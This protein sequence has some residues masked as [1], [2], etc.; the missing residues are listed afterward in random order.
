MEKLK[1]L[2]LIIFI[3][4]IT[5]SFNLGCAYQQDSSLLKDRPS[6]DT[7]NT[8]TE[9]SI[10]YESLAEKKVPP[11]V[12]ISQESGEIMYSTGPEELLFIEGYAMPGNRIDI[13]VNGVLKA[14]SLGVDQKGYFR[15]S[16]GVG[17]VEGNNS[18]KVVAK[19]SRGSKSVPTVF[20]VV[21]KTA[22]SI[23]Y[24]V[25]TDS[26]TLKEISEIYYTKVDNPTVYISGTYLPSS[27]I[28][29]EVNGKVV[30][31]ITSDSDGAFSFDEVELEKGENEIAVWAAAQ[32]GQASRPKFKNV[33]V[34]KDTSSPSPVNL[35]GYHDNSGNHLNWT[36]TID[37]NF[38][39]YKIVRV[40]DP[41][42]NPEYPTHDVIATINDSGETA[43]IDT[44]IDKGKSYYYTL[45]CLDKAGNVISSNVLALPKPVYSIAIEK[46]P[47][48]SA[49][50]IGRREWYYQYFEITNT[51]NV[52]VDLQPIMVWIKLDP[53]PDT[54][55]ELWPF[56]EAHIWD[57]DSGTYY[58]SNET[59]EETY[60]S[61]YW[62]VDGITEKTVTT[63]Y[64]EDETTKTVTEEVVTR[65]TEKSEG[66]RVMTTITKTTT[67]VTDLSTGDTEVEETT[68]ETTSLV[69]PEKIGSPI[70]DIGPGEKIKIAVKIQNISAGSGDEIICHFHF[71]PIDCAGYFF[72][73][74]EVS[75]RDITVIS[76]GRN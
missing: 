21:L 24:T 12:V 74:E 73:D 49:N 48:F 52:T 62:T 54:D 61:D 45:W 39:L 47:P 51:G 70:E 66:K 7:E 44:D 20:N 22:E 58:Y 53:E 1:P 69:E 41:C 8:G 71:A 14:Q 4:I 32:G 35:A 50:T 40:E 25:Y 33:L 27:H 68:D 5:A 43:Y 55:E 29:L 59:I 76:S 28:N 18:I 36:P 42:L 15:A 2:F 72:T 13:F 10:D 75:T 64:S 17:I 30:S 31:E 65:R 23:D 26:D 60:I 37:E 3:V 6:S 57:A 56:W 63:E 11:P 19:D 38:Y 16:S 34:T 67:T 46:I 9:I